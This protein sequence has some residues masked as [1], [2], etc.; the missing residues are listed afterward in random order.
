MPLAFGSSQ[1]HGFNGGVVS[2]A[3]LIDPK[4]ACSNLF[5]FA[6]ARGFPELNGFLLV[7]PKQL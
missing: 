5:G 7:S 2:L 3:F 4:S 1:T 6:S